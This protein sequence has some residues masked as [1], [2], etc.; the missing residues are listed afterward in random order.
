M[1]RSTVC[2]GPQMFDADTGAKPDRSAALHGDSTTAVRG[3]TVSAVHHLLLNRWFRPLP[4]LLPLGLV[5]TATAV[6]VGA[7]LAPEPAHSDAS[8][9]FHG[10]TLRPLAVRATSCTETDARPNAVLD[11]GPSAATLALDDESAL[12]VKT[13]DGSRPRG[14]TF[15]L[16]MARAPWPT[17]T[18]TAPR[19][20]SFRRGRVVCVTLAPTTQSCRMVRSSTGRL[21][22][23]QMVL[24][25]RPR[26]EVKSSLRLDARAPPPPAPRRPSAAATASS[27]RRPG[28]RARPPARRA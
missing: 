15:R 11:F 13:P 19:R 9:S 7:D 4:W 10:R 5:V 18:L 8:L 22:F 3:R 26:F 28:R 1:G 2:L 17:A 23:W 14:S 27:A 24:F 16:S 20:F 12:C 6:L 21:R 25:Q